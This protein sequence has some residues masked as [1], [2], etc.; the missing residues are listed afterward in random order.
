MYPR[1][2]KAEA[3]V[4]ALDVVECL[5]DPIGPSTERVAPPCSAHVQLDDIPRTLD[6]AKCWGR[7][8]SAR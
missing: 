7:V 4:N 2:P 8:S 6:L 5:H 1:R 3:L